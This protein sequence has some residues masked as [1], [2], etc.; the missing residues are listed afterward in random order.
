MALSAF[1]GTARFSHLPGAWENPSRR[2]ATA[3]FLVATFLGTRYLLAAL[4]NAVAGGILGGARPAAA[5]PGRR[6]ADRPDSRLSPA[7][8][9][10]RRKGT[11]TSTACHQEEG[12]P[13]SQ[14]DAHNEGEME[15]PDGGADSAAAAGE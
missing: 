15:Q 6:A 7:A 1:A 5:G 2:V 12:P 4:T 9:T 3:V 14:D 8:A 11:K 10:M 13:P